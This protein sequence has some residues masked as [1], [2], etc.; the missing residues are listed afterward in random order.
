[1]KPLQS[2]SAGT[3]LKYAFI[4][5]GKLQITKHVTHRNHNSKNRHC[6][7]VFETFSAIRESTKEKEAPAQ[8][9]QSAQP[10]PS[11]RTEQMAKGLTEGADDA[12]V[13]RFAAERAC[14]LPASWAARTA[15][16]ITT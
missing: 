3:V 10:T 1:M 13:R 2:P 9:P 15:A 5:P 8:R 14:Q 16:T 12:W 6:P 7:A 11:F 4:N